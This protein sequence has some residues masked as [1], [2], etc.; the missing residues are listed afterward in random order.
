MEDIIKLIEITKKKGQRSIQLVNQNFRKKEVSKDNILFESIL[1]GKY[2]TDEDA[3]KGM[4]KTDP[5]NRNYRNTKG[6]LKQKLLNHLYFLDYEKDIYSAYQKNEYECWHALHQCRILIEEGANDIALK[7]LPQLIKTAKDFEFVNI[8]LE[9]LILLRNEYAKLGKSTPFHETNKE[10][11]HVKL[12][13]EAIL[14]CEEL[15]YQT[16]VYINKSVSSQNKVLNKIP[17]VITKIEKRGKEFSSNYLE[18][19]AKKLQLTFNNITLRFRENIALCDQLEKKYLNKDNSEIL[20][21][22]DKLNLG[23]NKLLAYFNLKDIENGSRYAEKNLKIIKNGSDEWFEFIEYYFLLM[24]NGEKFE[25]A[26]EIFR[27]VRTNKNFNQLPDEIAQRWHI[28]RAYLIFVNDS[29]LLKWGFDIDEFIE[30]LPDYP[31]NLQGYSIAT[32]IIQYLNLLREGRVNDVRDRVE[33]LQQYSSIHLD[34]RH[35]YRNSIFIRMLGIVTE[36]EFNYELIEEKG[37]TYLKKLLKFNIPF[38]LKNE[39]EII[40][41][42]KLWSYILNILKTNK[43]YIHYRFYNPVE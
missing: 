22:L 19:L 16:L 32:L 33:E 10:L 41:Y 24:M 21:D 31:K 39:I 34:K 23:F 27:M 43:L 14:E 17:Q 20:V 8:S 11:K 40:P 42:E 15:Y 26:E 12:F 9:A 2:L 35:N 38:D 4:F 13:K 18:V 6:K 1:S 30:N 25:K 37:T 36:K 7:K 28:Y 3:A 29:K 5:G